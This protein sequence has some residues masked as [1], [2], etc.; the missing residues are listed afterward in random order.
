LAPL[1]REQLETDFPQVTL[2]KREFLAWYDK[3]NAASLDSG[4]SK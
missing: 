2:A 1:I 4:G 3:E